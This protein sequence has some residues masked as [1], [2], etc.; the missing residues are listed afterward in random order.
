[1]AELQF[2]EKVLRGLCSDASEVKKR[3]SDTCQIVLCEKQF[4][5]GTQD[6][7][8]QPARCVGRSTWRPGCKVA[9]RCLSPLTLLTLLASL[10]PPTPSWPALSSLTRLYGQLN[11]CEATTRFFVTAA[12]RYSPFT[13]SSVFRDPQSQLV[14]RLP[15]GTLPD[16]STWESCRTMPLV[17]GFLGNLQFP[18][19][20]ILA[21]LHTQLTHPHRL[22]RPRRLKP[23]KSLH[24]TFQTVDIDNV[25][26]R[27][28]FLCIVSL[29]WLLALHEQL[30]PHHGGTARTTPPT[31]L[32]RCTNNGRGRFQYNDSYWFTL[33]DPDTCITKLEGIMFV[34]GGLNPKAQ[35]AAL[36]AGCSKCWHGGSRC[37]G[38]YRPSLA[39]SS[40]SAALREK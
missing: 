40:S 18:H 12:R 3:G 23:P 1:M 7:C 14:V 32:R 16:F 39:A 35:M 37:S 38:E 19:S 22:S 17:V 24:S 27:L 34:K 25:F 9:S 6:G 8:V 33:N 2:L 4:S 20:F 10:P 15:A 28:R 36:G 13:A 29:C 21:L 11:S 26:S 5:V 30:R 31:L